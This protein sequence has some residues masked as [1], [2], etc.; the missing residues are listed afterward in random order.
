MM[1]SQDLQTHSYNLPQIIYFLWPVIP[2]SKKEK[3]LHP[4][5]AEAD[6]LIFG[7]Y[8]ADSIDLQVTDFMSNL[9]NLL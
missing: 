1:A 4:L 2:L 5:P 3:S 7:W 9:W 8:G 6:D